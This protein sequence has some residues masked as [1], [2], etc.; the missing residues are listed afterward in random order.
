RLGWIVAPDELANR[1]IVLRESLDLE[2]SQLI[3]RAVAD[4]LANDML[5][6][7]LEKLNRINRQRKNTL[8]AALE[9]EFA[10]LCA[11]WTKP[12]GGLFA[13]VTLP[14]SY[15]TWKLFESAVAK[16]V[17]Y[18]PGGAFAIEGGSQNTMRLN[19]SNATDENIREAVQR[20]AQ[21]IRENG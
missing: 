9:S 12:E 1:I 4:F 20:L 7:H 21:V 17:A 3:Q 11:T 14:E 2:T 5:D 19:F 8:M 13:W 18:I 6:S 10:D 15:D 16:N